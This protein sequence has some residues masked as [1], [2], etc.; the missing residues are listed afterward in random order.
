MEGSRYVAFRSGVGRR[1]GNYLNVTVCEIGNGFTGVT[2]YPW[3]RVAEALYRA[4]PVTVIIVPYST[5]WFRG[6]FSSAYTFFSVIFFVLL[7]LMSK[8]AYA[9]RLACYVLVV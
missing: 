8:T 4:Q 2:A 3:P 5:F 1:L 7:F 6:F 9:T